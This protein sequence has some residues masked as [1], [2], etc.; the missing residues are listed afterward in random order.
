MKRI[1]LT[2]GIATGKSTVARFLHQRLHVPVLDA[3][4]LT[5]QLVEPG[6][7]SLA[8]IVDHFGKAVLSPEGR[9]D[10]KAMGEIVRRD[11]EARKHLEAVLHPRVFRM[12][13]DWL[14]RKA[15]QAHRAAVVEAS[16]LV[17]TGS[18]RSFD[19][20]LVVT[21]TPERQVERMVRN[22]GMS[23]AMAR[24]WMASQL[25]SAQKEERASYVIQN[26]GTRQDLE[27]AVVETW[28]RITAGRRR[29]V[30]DQ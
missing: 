29:E 6:S 22:R 12:T 23:H 30:Q 24:Q 13:K 14:D 1:G 25:S 17:E 21:C 4:E 20:L 16:L 15:A 18:Y 28:D 5:R 2:G 9:L 19:L 8:E 27:R 11:P 10:R 26:N 7:A 3:D